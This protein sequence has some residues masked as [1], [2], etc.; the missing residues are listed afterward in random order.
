MLGGAG[1]TL[2]VLY[3][4]NKAG[5]ARLWPYL[6][7]GAVYGERGQE[8]LERD[9]NARAEQRQHPQREGDVG[10]R[11]NRPA[12]M[13]DGRLRTWPDRILPG[14][15]ALGGMLMPAL[16]YVAVKAMSVAAG[17]A[18]PRRVSGECRLTA[19]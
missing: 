13:L 14:I 8:D 9:R 18:Q 17:I 11:G 4:M 6:L 1:L 10:G 7:L 2:A 19:T 3:G 12:A 16:V 5:V 15:A